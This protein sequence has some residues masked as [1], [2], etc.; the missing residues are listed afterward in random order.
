MQTIALLL[1][2][3]RRIKK[4][5]KRKKRKWGE[6]NIDSLKIQLFLMPDIK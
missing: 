2:K 1:F 3:P 4:N 5:R 6:R